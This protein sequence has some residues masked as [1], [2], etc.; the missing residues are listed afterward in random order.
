MLG[1]EGKDNDEKKF[2]NFWAT[3]IIKI[4]NDKKSGKKGNNATQTEINAAKNKTG[5]TD[6]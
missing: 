2:G 5:R 4:I 3:R 6:E 1:Y